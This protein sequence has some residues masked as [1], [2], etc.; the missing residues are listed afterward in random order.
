[1]KNWIDIETKSDQSAVIL[2]LIIKEKPLAWITYDPVQL[3]EL[4]RLLENHRRAL[5]LPEPVP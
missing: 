5:V 3:D 2:T 4:I 1:M